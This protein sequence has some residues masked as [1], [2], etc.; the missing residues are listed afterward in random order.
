MAELYIITGPT[1]KQYIGATKSTGRRRFSGHVTDSK[2]TKPRGP[3]SYF[4]NALRKHGAD[5]F[6]VK[7]LVVGPSEFVFALEDAA[8]QSFGTRSPAGYN[9]Q[10]GGSDGGDPTEDVRH[11]MGASNR[12]K[13]IHPNLK[14]SVKK[15]HADRNGT[16]EY[17]ES[18]RAAIN[19]AWAKPSHR[20]KMEKVLAR[21]NAD[22][23]VRKQRSQKL[24]EMRQDPEFCRRLEEARR[25]NRQARLFNPDQLILL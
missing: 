1:G 11:R 3:G 22:P 5:N 6:T 15:Q 7:T 14:A 9:T 23:K 10:R 20:E 4:Q 16:E 21:N 12:G 13:T 24:K 25:R 17:S 18:Q 19:A 2:R 8:I